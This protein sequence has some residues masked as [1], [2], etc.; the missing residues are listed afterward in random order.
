[1][2]DIRYLSQRAIE[3]YVQLNYVGPLVYISGRKMILQPYQMDAME[4]VEDADF[5]FGASTH[6]AIARYIGIEEGSERAI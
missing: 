1:M 2:K 3:F 6:V 4:I 5:C